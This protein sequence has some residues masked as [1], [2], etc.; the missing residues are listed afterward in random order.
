M[1]KDEKEIVLFLLL[2]LSIN[3]HFTALIISS[4]KCGNNLRYMFSFVLS[5]KTLD[6]DLH[7]LFFEKI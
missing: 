3:R 5:E 7:K 6:I 2:S 4:T 1:Q